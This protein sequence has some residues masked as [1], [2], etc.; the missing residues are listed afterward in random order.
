VIKTEEYRNHT[1]GFCQ[2]LFL[3]EVP[4]WSVA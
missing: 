1:V 4:P 3:E 2:V